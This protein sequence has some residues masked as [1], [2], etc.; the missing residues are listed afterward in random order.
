EKNLDLSKSLISEMNTTFNIALDGVESYLLGDLN[1]A[2]VL[3]GNYYSQLNKLPNH[4]LINKIYGTILLNEKEYDLALEIL[5][6]AVEIV[7]DDL[8]LHIKLRA[9]YSIKS[10]I[11]GIKIEEDII[12]LLEVR[13]G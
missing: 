5:R 13:H 11:V 1:K 9:L 12:E 2:K 3:L 10:D 7:P 8:D 4:Y 6:R